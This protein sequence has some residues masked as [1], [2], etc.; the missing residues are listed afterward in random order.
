MESPE[1][2]PSVQG[3]H[4]NVHLQLIMTVKERTSSLA[5]FLPSQSCRNK[6]GNTT[7]HRIFSTL[8]VISEMGCV[9]QRVLVTFHIRTVNVAASMEGCDITQVN[10][11]A[12]ASLCSFHLTLISSSQHST[13]IPQLLWPTLTKWNNIHI[14]S[15][16]FPPSG[17]CSSEGGASVQSSLSIFLMP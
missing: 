17:K 10:R 8:A 5:Y 15:G 14:R 1:A 3:M 12:V 2:F 11:N 13:S 7:T 9:C 16:F 6:I 4:P